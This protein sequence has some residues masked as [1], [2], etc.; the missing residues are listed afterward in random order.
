MPGW[1]DPEVNEGG[2]GSLK[3]NN[4]VG[5][6]GVVR[7]PVIQV[8]PDARGVAALIEQFAQDKSVTTSQHKYDTR[9]R[10]RRV[11]ELSS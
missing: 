11:E 4:S 2:P 3:A 10:T 1:E 6:G 7:E 8:L 5:V 9:E